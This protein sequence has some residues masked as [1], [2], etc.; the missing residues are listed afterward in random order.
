[1]QAIGGGR[2][3]PCDRESAA[4]ELGAGPQAVVDYLKTVPD[5]TLGE[6]SETFVGRLP[7]VE[8][9]ITARTDS[10]T[11][12][13][14]WLWVEQ[15]EALTAIPHELVVR[16][17]AMDVGTEHVVLTVFG[18]D[19]N[20]GWT[21][22][23]YQL[24][25]SL[26]FGFRPTSSVGGPSVADAFLR[27]FEFTPPPGSQMV[28]T[29]ASANMYSFSEGTTEV[30]PRANYSP[31]PGLRGSTV[32]FGTAPSTHGDSYPQVPLSLE[33]FLAD[34][35]ANTMLVVGETTATQLAGLA[36]TQAD[37]SF[38]GDIRAST[39]YPDLHVASNVTLDLEFPSRLI[40]AQTHGGVIIV[41][42]WAGTEDEFS[43]WLPRAVTFVESFEFV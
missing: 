28:V 36:A 14:I 26:R 39:G 25:S 31:I 21:D 4:L 32:S 23:A 17:V 10:S 37:V 3:D 16:V 20:A 33:D 1:M 5:L 9:R 11:C 2:V 6:E 13:E 34:L 15:T 24:I 29:R 27:P 7:A 35:A 30:Y 22:I 42:I 43:A 18:E 12:D 8:A 40:V 19:E 41:H 38:I